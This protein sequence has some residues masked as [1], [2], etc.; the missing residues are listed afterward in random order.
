MTMH[1]LLHIDT[2]GLEYAAAVCTGR[3]YT[4]SNFRNVSE[5]ALKILSKFYGFSVQSC[6]VLVQSKPH[7]RNVYV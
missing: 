1:K 6:A 2:L 4:A 5:F 7:L 3:M